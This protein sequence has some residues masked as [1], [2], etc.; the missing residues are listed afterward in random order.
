MTLLEEILSHKRI[1]VAKQKARVPLTSMEALARA[2]PPA[3]DF[4][5]GLQASP[6]QPALI[7]EVKRASP[8]RGLLLAD[9]DP[10]NLARL[11]YQNGA[12][13]ISVLT[14]SKFFQGDVEHLQAI[15][16]QTTSIHLLRKDFIYDPY[17]VYQSRSA[18]A[19]AVLLITAILP[20]NLL[21]ELHSL[22]LQLGMTPLIEV[23]NREELEIA[24]CLDPSLIGIN[25]R[26]LHDFS[27]DLDTTRR[28][29]KLIPP[30]TR[31]VAESGIHTRSDVLQMAEAGADAVL[32][33]EALVCAPDVAAQ[34]RMLTGGQ[35]NEG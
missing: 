2:T 3:K 35:S 10:L 7:A 8:S 24:L 11:Y 28:L 12:A 13:A 6:S 15:A 21:R 18:G 25:N 32:V 26:N 34:V 4:V 29:R 1:E 19:D 23:H 9:F 30:E 27:V 33:G 20:L 17:Q 14:D 31:V 16:R 5:E 22:S